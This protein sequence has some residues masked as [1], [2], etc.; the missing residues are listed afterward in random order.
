[1]SLKVMKVRVTRGMRRQGIADILKKK[2]F[3]DFINEKLGNF[4]FKLSSLI[5]T[6]LLARILGPSG[7]G[8]YTILLSLSLL[9]ASIGDLG[10]PIAIV[11]YLASVEKD[12]QPV[13]FKF[14]IK[15]LFLSSFIILLSYFFLWKSLSLIFLKERY[16][17]L[18]F[19]SFTLAILFI[20]NSTLRSVFQAFK[21]FDLG[22]NL[23]FLEGLLKVFFIISLSY[24]LGVLGSI[25]GFNI[26]YFLLILISIYLIKKNFS[27]LFQKTNFKIDKKEVLRY[28]FFVNL[29]TAGRSLYNWLDSLI[30][31]SL[32][33]PKSV[34]YY[35]VS[36]ALINTVLLFSGIQGILAPRFAKWDINYIKKKLFTFILINLLIS[37]PIFFI[38]NLF[39]E[40]IILFIYGKD[41]LGALPLI[42]V[43]SFLIILNSFAFP[44]LIF[45]MKG[46]PEYS[47]LVI[48]ISAIVNAIADY[49]L[50]QK[51]GLIGAVYATIIAWVTSLAV[52]YYIL[53]SRVFRH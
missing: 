17:V 20:F 18:I 51:I 4:L 36:F 16:P 52:G 38:F 35:R 19:L 27:F 1:M 23:A 12:K 42:R 25:M 30:I 33:D 9:I 29:L 26:A 47:A 5:L 45:N 7:Y 21:R 8:M 34:S 48:F 31:A 50:I 44:I 46:Y 41:Y 40:W 2:I 14:F 37:I 11:R 3:W 39:S 49:F 13:Y 24:F 43:L 10:V 15:L 22:R 28:L 53:R 6:I 32:L